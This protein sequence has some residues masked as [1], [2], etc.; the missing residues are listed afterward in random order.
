MAREQIGAF[1]VTTAQQILA[2]LAALEAGSHTK[3]PWA[4]RTQAGP[5]YTR[6][7]FRNGDTEKAP[8]YALMQVTDTYLLDGDKTYLECKRPTDI[9]GDNGWY[10]VNGHTATEPGAEGQCFAGPEVRVRGTLGQPGDR[11]APQIGSWDAAPSQ[12]GFIV[13]AGPDLLSRVDT[14]R[15]FIG[16]PGQEPPAGRIRFKTITKMTDRQCWAEVVEVLGL[17]FNL[18]TGQQLQIGDTVILDDINNEWPEADAFAT[19]MA[20]LLPGRLKANHPTLPANR[21]PAWQIEQITL[22]VNR[23][24]AF[25]GQHILKTAAGGVAYIRTNNKLESVQPADEVAWKRSTW[26]NSDQPNEFTAIGQQGN[27]LQPASSRLLVQFKNPFLKD[28][29][30]P[31]YSGGAGSGTGGQEYRSVILQRVTGDGFTDPENVLLNKAN[32]ESP[33]VEWQLVEVEEPIARHC[34][35]TIV[36]TDIAT[37]SPTKYYDGGDPRAGNNPPFVLGCTPECVD[38]NERVC[39]KADYSPEDHQYR[40]VQIKQTMIE[41]DVAIDGFFDVIN[42]D[43]TVD[44]CLPLRKITVCSVVDEDKTTCIPFGDCE[45]LLP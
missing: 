27:P 28:A 16:S 30:G 19:G 25:I 11:Y 35:G 24:R 15:M 17:A 14:H 20:F 1:T 12:I 10:V 29:I 44:K 21:P 23:V 13:Y 22:P 41:L 3:T 5:G 40:I 33:T 36:G 45:D 31:I 42:P 32:L 34:E 6:L 43:G 9:T 37:V 2:R 18:Q 7:F 8:P 38:P 4:P 39:F 26:P